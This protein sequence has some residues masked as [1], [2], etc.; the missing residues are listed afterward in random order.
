MRPIAIVITCSVNVCVFGMRVNCARNV[1]T[2]RDAVWG[3][4]H[5]GQKSHVLDGGPDPTRKG[6]L[7]KGK[8]LANC[9]LP[10]HECIAHRSPAA[11]DECACSAH[12]TDEC[13]LSRK[14]WQHGDAAFCQ[15][16]L[17]TCYICVFGSVVYR[18]TFDE[19]ILMKD[20]I[21]RGGF[22]TGDNIMWHRPVVILQSA[23]ARCPVVTEDWM[24]S[25]LHT[26]LHRLPMLFSD[27]VIPLNCSF[28]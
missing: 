1:W 20:C 16:T 24:I 7:L 21:A 12:A 4:N 14:R 15:I 13:I 6:A 8:G 28:P 5:V 9:S 22:F 25:V 23:A 18:Q 27:Q 26:L 17:N 2:D 19:R 3:L 10:T 11:A